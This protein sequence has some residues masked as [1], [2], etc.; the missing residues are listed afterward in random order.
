[1]VFYAIRDN[2]VQVKGGT[3]ASKL[4]ISQRIFGF[5]GV[6]LTP[7]GTQKSTIRKHHFI[8]SFTKSIINEKVVLGGSSEVPILYT[9]I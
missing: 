1:M 9:L 7:E 3:K 6:I 4:N 8:H 5:L 2:W